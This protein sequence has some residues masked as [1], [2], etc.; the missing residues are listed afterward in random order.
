VHLIDARFATTSRKRNQRVRLRFFDS[1]KRQV[2]RVVV[3][4]R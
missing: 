2:G 3:P 4:P 1:R